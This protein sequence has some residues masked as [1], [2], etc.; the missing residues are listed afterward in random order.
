MHAFWGSGPEPH[1]KGLFI[2][3]SDNSRDNAN[4]KSGLYPFTIAHPLA[5]V[6]LAAVMAAPLAAR[7][8]KVDHERAR[9][10]V[11][12]GEVLPLPL[13]L[14]RLQREQPGQVLEVELEQAKGSG[15]WIYEIRLLKA[16]G[17]LV[18]LKLDA[19]TGTVMAGGERLRDQDRKPD[20]GGH[21]RPR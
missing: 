18:K 19:R 3:R 8:D 1:L 11:Q 5:A 13:L 2:S 10:A 4:M 14:E 7:A 17:G 9:Q 12:A 20:G 21:S 16:G 15:Q 6:L